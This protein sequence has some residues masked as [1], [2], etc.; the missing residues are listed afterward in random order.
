V[1]AYIQRRFN[2]YIPARGRS[3]GRPEDRMLNALRDFLKSLGG[4]NEPGKQFDE[5]DVRLALA[6]LLA[7][8]MSIDGVVEET[9]KAQLRAVLEK[10][11]DIAGEDL[12]KLIDEAIRADDEAVDLYGFTSILKRNMEHEQRL[13]VVEHLWEMVYADGEVH[14]FEDNLVWRIAE[15]LGVQSRDRIARRAR[16]AGR[17]ES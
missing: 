12:D 4:E 9:E 7:H 2:A 10:E 6:A 16:V 17:T 11:Y 14:E 3:A 8:A 15:L 5:T 13:R 1:Q